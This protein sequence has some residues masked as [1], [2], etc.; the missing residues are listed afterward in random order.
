MYFGFQALSQFSFVTIG[1]Y[2]TMIGAFGFCLAFLIGRSTGGRDALRFTRWWALAVLGSILATILFAVL[3]G[4]WSRFLIEYGV[5]PLAEMGV[6]AAGWLLIM[7]FMA[8]QYALGRIDL[9]DKFGIGNKG[10]NG[11]D[12]PSCERADDAST[13]ENTTSEC[14]DD[15]A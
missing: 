15:H 3:A 9:D 7:W 1:F 14:E 6:L 4:Q 8:T 10:N 11:A 2:L 5:G 13:A 12:D